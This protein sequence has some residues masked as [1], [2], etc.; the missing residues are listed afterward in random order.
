MKTQPRASAM[1]QGFKKKLFSKEK[2]SER[3]FFIFF[4]S[5]FDSIIKIRISLNVYSVSMVGAVVS[6]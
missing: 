4:H 6:N 5:I 1:R 2:T 3:F